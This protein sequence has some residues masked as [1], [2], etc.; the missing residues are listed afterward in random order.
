M[1]KKMISFWT[2]PLKI[3]SQVYALTVAATSH[4]QCWLSLGSRGEEDL[5]DWAGRW[6]P[7]QKLLREKEPNT[8]ILAETEE[9]LAR[10]RRQFTLPLHLLGTPFQLRVWQELRQIPY[11]QTCSY[12]DIARRIGCPRGCRA[13]GAANSQNTLALVIPCHRVILK[14]GHLGGYSG[15]PEL[16]K[17]LLQLEKA[18]I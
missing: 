17:K 18:D 7:G 8:L 1:E 6:L 10:K 4:G 15:G 3:S 2:G 9:Y 5:A 12:A 11:G 14:D 16:K 13:V